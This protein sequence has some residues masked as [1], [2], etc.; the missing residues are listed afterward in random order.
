MVLMIEK[1]YS[2]DLRGSSS[3]VNTPLSANTFQFAGLMPLL[4]PWH[5]PRDTQWHRH[6]FWNI[7]S[8]PTSSHPTAPTLPS[9]I[10]LIKPFPFSEFHSISFCYVSSLIMFKVN[11]ITLY[12]S[13]L[14]SGLMWTMCDYGGGVA[15]L[16]K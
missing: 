7:R 16:Q 13:P 6:P 2:R 10:K 14:L 3:L 12:Q 8:T 9:L 15:W 11:T 1:F 4:Y 5:V